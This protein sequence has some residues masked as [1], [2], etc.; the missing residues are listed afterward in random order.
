MIISLGWIGL[1]SGMLDHVNVTSHGVQTPLPHVAAVSVSSLE[2]LTVMPYDAT[3]SPVSQSFL[4]LF[5]G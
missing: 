2:T 4:F 1:V 3:V 5:V